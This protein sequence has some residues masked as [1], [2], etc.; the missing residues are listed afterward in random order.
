MALIGA[1][2][3]ES[4]LAALAKCGI[5]AAMAEYAQLCRVD[6]FTGGEIV[7]RNGS[8]NYAGIVFPYRWPQEPYIRE[9]RLRDDEPDVAQPI[10]KRRRK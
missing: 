1:P 2:L 10:A 6:S 7:G 3:A 4:D 5:D 8:G 9:Y